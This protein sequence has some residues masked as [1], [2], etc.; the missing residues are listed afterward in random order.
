MI[1]QGEIR[2]GLGDIQ[3]EGSIK[4]GKLF[5]SK[6]DITKVWN[7]LHS[8]GL[9]IRGDKELPD[10]ICPRCLGQGRL[11]DR[12]GSKADNSSGYIDTCFECNGTGKVKAGYVAVEPLVRD[13]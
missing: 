13:D 12:I 4:E 1:K 2:E 3:I 6:S 7:Y 10:K 11:S 8:Q 9:V 5:L